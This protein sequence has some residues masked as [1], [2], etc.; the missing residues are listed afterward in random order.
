M[1]VIIVVPASVPALELTDKLT[2]GVAGV[3]LSAIVIF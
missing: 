3:S 1:T 2:V